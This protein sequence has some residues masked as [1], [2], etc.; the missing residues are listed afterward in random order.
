MS[1]ERGSRRRGFRLRVFDDAAQEIIA[2]WVV[3]LLIAVTGLAFIS[4]GDVGGSGSVETRRAPHA[5]G[6]AQRPSWRTEFTCA[7][8]EETA[9]QASQGSDSHREEC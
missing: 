4:F 8:E 3:A 7:R 9:E 6:S 1:F 2:A 5:A